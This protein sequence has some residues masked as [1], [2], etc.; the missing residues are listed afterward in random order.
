M[1]SGGLMQL[2]AYGAQDAYL[3]GNP[4]ITFLKTILKRHTEISNG[5]KNH[6]D[7]NN[8]NLIIRYNSA[9]LIWDN[10][11]LL[12]ININGEDII[13]NEEGIITIII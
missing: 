1:V 9:D 4:Q 11:F 3:S 8:D 13:I 5:I 7:N 10:T 12:F 6:I 2:I